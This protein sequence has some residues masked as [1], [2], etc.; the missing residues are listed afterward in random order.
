ME[1]I[2]PIDKKDYSQSKALDLAQN[3]ST[4][5]EVLDELATIIFH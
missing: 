3:P 4:P 2:Y 5:S 1:K